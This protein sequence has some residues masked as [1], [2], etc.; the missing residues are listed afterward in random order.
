M[1]RSLEVPVTR[2]DYLVYFINTIAVY[3]VESR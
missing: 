2:L 1:H 3:A